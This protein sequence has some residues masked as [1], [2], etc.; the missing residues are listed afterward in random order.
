MV[1]RRFDTPPFLKANVFEAKIEIIQSEKRE[2]YLENNTKQTLTGQNKSMQLLLIFLKN[3]V[4]IN[5]KVCVFVNVVHIS[6]LL[7]YSFSLHFES[8]T[9]KCEFIGIVKEYANYKKLK[10]KQKKLGCRAI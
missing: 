6:H 2:K 4:L 9:Y 5:S 3:V 8:K 10:K 1:G 7:S